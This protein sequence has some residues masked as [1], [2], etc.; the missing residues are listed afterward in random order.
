MY[1]F[2]DAMLRCDDILPR[3][4]NSGSPIRSNPNPHCHFR[5]TLKVMQ[6]NGGANLTQNCVAVT[7]NLQIDFERKTYSYIPP[8]FCGKGLAACYR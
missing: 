5:N 6:S 7:L 3:S 8:L 2:I 4:D 1:F